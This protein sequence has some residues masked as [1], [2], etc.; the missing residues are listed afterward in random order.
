MQTKSFPFMLT[1]ADG[2]VLHSRSLGRKGEH[3]MSKLEVVRTEVASSTTRSSWGRV[4]EG[5]KMLSFAECSPTVRYRNR[6]VHLQ[7]VMRKARIATCQ[8]TFIP[9]LELAIV[10]KEP[11]KPS[12]HS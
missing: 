8:A 4:G 12:S 5:F 7:L 11:G 6:S 1:A 9:C 3:Y 10:T 2:A